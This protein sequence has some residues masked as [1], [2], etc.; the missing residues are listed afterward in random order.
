MIENCQNQ[1]SAS[2]FKLLTS[3]KDLNSADSAESLPFL[4]LLFK[5]AFNLQEGFLKET[6]AVVLLEK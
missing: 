1:G 6:E 3:C 2:Y 5:I 4:I